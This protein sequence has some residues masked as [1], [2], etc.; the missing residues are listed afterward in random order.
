MPSS[1]VDTSGTSALSVCLAATASWPVSASLDML[2]RIGSDRFGILSATMERQGWD[3]SVAVIRASGLSPVFVAGGARAVHGDDRGWDRILATLTRSIDA[4]VE[5][6]AP[7]VCFTSGGSGG[8]SWEE[9]AEAAVLRFGPLVEY[10]TGR[11]IALALENTM[12]I[13]SA[14]SFTHSVA[15]TAALARELG[16]GLMVDLY[17][18]WQERGLMATIA[19][20]LDAVRVVQIGDHRTSATSVPDRW[21]P[22]D[23]D[24]PLERLVR[25]VRALGYRGPVDLELLGPAIDDEGAESALGRGWKWMCAHVP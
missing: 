21:V 14:M 8:L 13:R 24:I 9:A 20:N 7:T 19:D 17:S 16:V 6:G 23:G 12:S 10:A 5:I 25:E 15:D 1:T 2:G 4:A 18:A 11:G 22:G 3:D